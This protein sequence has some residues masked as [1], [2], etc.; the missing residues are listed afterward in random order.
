M[1]MKTKAGGPSGRKALI[2]LLALALVVRLVRLGAESLWFDEAFSVTAARG[3]WG[4][5]FATVVADGRHPPLSFLVLRGSLTLLGGLGIELASRLPSVFVST[6]EVALAWRLGRLLVGHRAAFIGAA[7]LALA[8]LSVRQAQEARMYA[9]A[10]CLVVAAALLVAKALFERRS[11]VLGWAGLAGGLALL[12]HY[13][14][15]FS[16]VALVAWAW[17]LRRTRPC[18]S[19]A[20]LGAAVALVVVVT[21]W[22]AFGLPAQLE[23][24]GELLAE[25]APEWGRVSWS[26]LFVAPAFLAGGEQPRLGPNP[27]GWALVTAWV[28]LIATALLAVTKVYRASDRSDARDG[29]LGLALLVGVPIA[30]ALLAGALTG[31]QFAVRYLLP[32]LGPLLLLAAAGLLA[33]RPRALRLGALTLAFVFSLG[34]V[35]AVW[36]GGWKPEWR[37]FVA[38]LSTRAAA[39]DGVLWLP[40]GHVPLQWSLY[41]GEDREPPRAVRSDLTDAEQFPRVWL[42]AFAANPA[43]RS[44]LERQRRAVIVTHVS[45]F[46]WSAPPLSLELFERR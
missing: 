34:G 22:I 23:R 7:L 16:L 40:A 2:A 4:E 36:R 39:E 43:Y 42:A 17:T 38:E 13:W 29:V 5:L 10:S 21:P 15:V 8:Q 24:S 6:I 32:T 26:T 45:T 30:L 41:A 27:A 11:G 9:L 46:S 14:T 44:D 28:L 1:K 25:G 20:W 35:I 12:A 19:R 33:L 37:S 18:P 3:S 31:A